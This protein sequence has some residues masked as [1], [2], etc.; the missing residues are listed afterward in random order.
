MPGVPVTLESDPTIRVAPFV[1][2]VTVPVATAPA[3]VPVKFASA[4]PDGAVPLE[5]LTE[6]TSQPA[7]AMMLLKTAVIVAVVPLGTTAC[8]REVV[9][10][11]PPAVFR[12]SAIRVAETPPMVTLFS[13]AV[14]LAPMR[15]VTAA[16]TRPDLIA[17]ARLAHVYVDKVVASWAL[18]VLEM[19]TPVA[20][21]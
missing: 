18:S 17:K 4:A 9:V 5:P 7:R 20:D 14:V 19:V 10:R 11:E 12:L 6:K 15:D 13:V 1:G 2:T 16:T 8:Q 21:C 3:L